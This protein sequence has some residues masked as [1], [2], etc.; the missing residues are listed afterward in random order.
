VICPD[1]LC[2]HIGHC[3]LGCDYGTREEPAELLKGSLCHRDVWRWKRVVEG[4]SLEAKVTSNADKVIF[5]DE[6]GD[7]QQPTMLDQFFDQ[8]ISDLVLQYKNK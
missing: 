7:K 8:L 4:H 1:L 2:P 5:V 6:Y 3:R